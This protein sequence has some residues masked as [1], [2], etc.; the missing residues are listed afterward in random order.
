[1]AE[2]PNRPG[3]LI[4]LTGGIA[5]GKSTVSR[6]LRTA[7]VPVVDADEVARSVV[8]PGLPAHREIVAC[9]GQGVLQPDGTIDRERLGRLVF[10]D[11]AALARLNAITHPAIEA[12]IAAQVA[13]LQG[14]NRPVVVD[15]PLLFEVGDPETYDEVVLVYV[16]RET[17]IQR[18]MA[19]DGLTRTDA[20]QR[21]QAQLPIE[22]K[23][24]RADRIIDNRG[25][26]D[27]TRAQVS[28]LLADWGLPV[29]S[30]T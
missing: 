24:A 5:T 14:P 16:D 19:R 25:T 12:E 21:L 4:G 13:R 29:K 7:G 15:I 26:L 23:V 18:L 8:R 27:Q 30:A 2:R 28:A 20:V 1:M 10:S 6:M 3:P 11:R 17:Q 9:F 22:T